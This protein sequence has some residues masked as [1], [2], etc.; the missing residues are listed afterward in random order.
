MQ[1]TGVVNT[2]KGYRTEFYLVDTATNMIP[3]RIVAPTNAGIAVCAVNTAPIGWIGYEDS[4]PYYQPA[5]ITT[6]YAKNDVI[7]IHSGPA[8]FMGCIASGSNCLPGDL[9]EPAGD[10][11]LKKDTGNG[12]AC[13]AAHQA[14]DASSSA[15]RGLVDWFQP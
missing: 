12:H 8:T 15:K 4:H 11:E 1:P 9:L 2:S 3:G 7:P 5:S 10:G 6:A 13:A 14:I